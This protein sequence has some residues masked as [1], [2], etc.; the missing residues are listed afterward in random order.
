MKISILSFTISPASSTGLAPVS[1]QHIF[2]GGRGGGGRE[3]FLPAQ[4]LQ[5][6][7]STPLSCGG[8]LTWLGLPA[9]SAA[10]SLWT[11]RTWGLFSER[12]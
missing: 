6:Q 5:L 10:I 11:S 9:Q 7:G 12:P 8:A 4:P 3:D 1:A 2:V